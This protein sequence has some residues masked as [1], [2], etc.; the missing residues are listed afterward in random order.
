M[1]ANMFKKVK[2]SF[3][4]ALRGAL[5]DDVPWLRSRPPKPLPWYE[6][7]KDV[8]EAISFEILLQNLFRA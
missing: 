8:N 6:T 5:H 7:L 4:N 3:A 1:I 2:A